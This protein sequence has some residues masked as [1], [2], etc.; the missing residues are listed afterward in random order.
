MEIRLEEYDKA[1]SLLQK[2]V[3]D[4]PRSFTKKNTNTTINNNDLSLSSSSEV[5][6]VS[7]SSRPS[8][9]SLVYKNVKIWN[10]YLDLEESVGTLDTCRSAYERAIGA[11]FNK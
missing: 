1:L 11:Q 3:S 9:L 6:A 5:T 2:V 10:L 8:S 4:P 7:S